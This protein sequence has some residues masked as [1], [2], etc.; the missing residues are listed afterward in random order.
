MGAGDDG[1][2]LGVL[3]LRAYTVIKEPD[4]LRYFMQLAKW[5]SVLS[6]LGFS[7]QTFG[8][9]NHQGKG[10]VEPS[11]PID[12]GKEESYISPVVGDDFAYISRVIDDAFGFSN[13]RR[14][15][16]IEDDQKSA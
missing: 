2:W 12:S 7:S 3:G 14:T 4:L 16:E 11:R 5:F 10:T 9:V 8:D 1:G 6:L 13:S 15:G